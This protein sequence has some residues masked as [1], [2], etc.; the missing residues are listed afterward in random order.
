MQSLFNISSKVDKKKIIITKKNISK[1]LKNTNQVN[2]KELNKSIS[3]FHGLE[4]IRLKKNID[5]FAV[6]CWP[7][8]NVVLLGFY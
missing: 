7:T 1:N 8:P 3:L 6:R 2:K 4:N 5:A